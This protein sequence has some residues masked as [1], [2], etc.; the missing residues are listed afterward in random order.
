MLIAHSQLVAQLDAEMRRV[1]QIPLDWYDVLVQLAEAGGSLTM[2]NLAAS[3]LIGASRCSRRVDRLVRAEL[4]ERRRDSMDSRV[5]HAE[6]TASGRALQRRAAITHLGGIQRLFG[7]FVDDELATAMTGALR[8]A[9]AD[10][11][12]PPGPDDEPGTGE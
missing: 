3:L 11:D 2:G 4:V 8:A 9:V 7:Q 12:E 10:I 1:H 5:V 6:L